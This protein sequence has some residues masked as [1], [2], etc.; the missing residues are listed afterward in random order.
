MRARRVAPPAIIGG[1]SEVRG[2]KVGGRDQN[3][4]V[5]RV[6]PLRVAAAL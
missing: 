6:T 1:L 2:A 5:T 3:G 4:R